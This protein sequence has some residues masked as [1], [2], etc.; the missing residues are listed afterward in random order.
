[1][2]LLLL[3]KAVLFNAVLSDLCKGRKDSRP[4]SVGGLVFMDEYSRV[5]R[6]SNLTP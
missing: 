2:S 5:A 1:M 3:G 6:V 4:P